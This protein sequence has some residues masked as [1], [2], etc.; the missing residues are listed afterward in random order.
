MDEFNYLPF[1]NDDSDLLEAEEVLLGEFPTFSVQFDRYFNNFSTTSALHPWDPESSNKETSPEPTQKV[2]NL[3][4]TRFSE[5]S[6]EEIEELNTVSAVHKSTSRSTKQWM[7]V[8]K[9][10]CQ[11][12]HL[13]NVNIETMA[14]EK[15]D[16]ILSKF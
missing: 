15:L 2:Q 16:D 14:P 8:L 6:C 5:I 1:L 12:H 7:N 9:S 3:D 13:Q 10:W 11:S 4:S